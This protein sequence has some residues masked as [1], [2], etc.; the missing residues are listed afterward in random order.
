MFAQIP[1]LGKK[2]MPRS[3]W[4]MANAFH[5]CIRLARGF[6]LR[7][8]GRRAVR[9]RDNSTITKGIAIATFVGGKYPSHATGNHAAIYLSQNKVGIVVL[10]QWK[11]QGAVK[12]RT[13]RFEVPKG[14]SASNDG[15][16]FS[17]IE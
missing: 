10:D 14:T 16:A 5:S 6:P 3:R 7:L 8:P 13:I 4:A 2:A 11:R 9:S 1:N 15:N 12:R 17:V